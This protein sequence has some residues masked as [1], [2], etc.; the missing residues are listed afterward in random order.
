MFLSKR[1]SHK[2]VTDARLLNATSDVSKHKFPRI[3]VQVS[4]PR[5]K[6]KVFSTTDLPTFH[7]QGELPPETQN[8]VDSVV[9]KEQYK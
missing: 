2:L 8:Q 3:T 1:D 5:I 6:G 4:I 9:G 7:H